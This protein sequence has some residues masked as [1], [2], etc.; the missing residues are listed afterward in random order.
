MRP[1]KQQLGFRKTSSNA[2]FTTRIRR[3]RSSLPGGISSEATHQ[4]DVWGSVC[5]GPCSEGNHS[6]AVDASARI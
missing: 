1:A 6:Y 5:W 2:K 4:D 3:V